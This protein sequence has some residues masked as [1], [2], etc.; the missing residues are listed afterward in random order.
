M[1]LYSVLKC[2]NEEQ[3]N[4]N[5][6]ILNLSEKNYY[7]KKGKIKYVNRNPVWLP[8]HVVSHS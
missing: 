8:E 1:L 4:F 2:L 5:Q 7:D 6:R 3:L